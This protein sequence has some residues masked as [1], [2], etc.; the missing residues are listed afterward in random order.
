MGIQATFPDIVSLL[1]SLVWLQLPNSDNH[2]VRT[3]RSRRLRRVSKIGCSLIGIKS[4]SYGLGGSHSKKSSSLSKCQ[5]NSQ[6][7]ASKFQTY[8]VTLRRKAPPSIA[9]KA[10]THSRSRW[11]SSESAKSTA[12]S[13]TSARRPSGRS[14]SFNTLKSLSPPRRFSSATQPRSFRTTALPKRHKIRMRRLSA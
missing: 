12:R 14:S 11:S 2:G 8:F 10:S 9:S 7:R 6:T 1:T 5:S 4:S 13:S 3:L